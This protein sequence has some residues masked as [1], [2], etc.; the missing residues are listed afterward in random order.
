MLVTVFFPMTLEQMLIDP[1]SGYAALMPESTKTR[2]TFPEEL[3]LGQP[4]IH[5]DDV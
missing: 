2:K 4:I 1:G 3:V 5:L